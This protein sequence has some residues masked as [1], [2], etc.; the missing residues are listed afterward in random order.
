M[1]R[2]QIYSKPDGSIGVRT[3]PKEGAL[4]AQQQFKDKC[5]INSIMRKYHKTGM[6]DH[7][8]R[9]PGQYANLL[10]VKDYDSALQ[11][12][13]SARDSF[14]TLPSEVRA[15]FGNEPQGVIDFLKDPKN[16]DEGVKLGLLTPR[17]IP[18]T[19]KS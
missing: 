14:M 9:T 15:R 11:T 3:L 8:R 1:S 2:K 18:E 12:V 6:I 5:N 19:P 10:D 13:I 7:L 16:Y 17:P 4:E